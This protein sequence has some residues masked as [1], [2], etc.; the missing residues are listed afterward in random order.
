MQTDCNEEL[1]SLLQV[2]AIFSECDA[3]RAILISKSE[4]RLKK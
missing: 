2:A 1:P 4:V 3:Q